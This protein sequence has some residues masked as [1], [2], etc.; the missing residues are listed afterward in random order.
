MI[1]TLYDHALENLVWFTHGYILRSEVWKYSF[2]PSFFIFTNLTKIQKKLSQRFEY[3]Y[4]YKLKV[5]FSTL[6]RS[7]FFCPMSWHSPVSWFRFA[8][9]LKW[10]YWSDIHLEPDILQNWFEI[11][12]AQI[13]KNYFNLSKRIIFLTQRLVRKALIDVLYLLLKYHKGLFLSRLRIF[14]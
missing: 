13:K 5:A 12:K 14:F 4:R 7:T 6:A 9:Y 8:N 2:Q 10:N 3:L 11:G 1:Q